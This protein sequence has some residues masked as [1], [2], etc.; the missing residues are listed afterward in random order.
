MRER[1]YAFFTRVIAG[2]GAQ[3]KVSPKEL[4]TYE[5]K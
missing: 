3:F 5:K 4:R 2:R 1:G